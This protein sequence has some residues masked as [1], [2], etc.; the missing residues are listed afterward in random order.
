MNVLAL[1]ALV[2][3]SAAPAA[4]SEDYP[5]EPVRAVARVEPG[6]MVV[7]LTA[8][9]IY[10][11]EEILLVNPPPP[12]DWDADLSARAQAYVN[13]HLR[14]TTRGNPLPGR[15]V[16]ARWVQRL[17]QAHEQGS[18][19]LRLV[20]PPPQA[21]A[22]LSGR[23][24]FYEEYRRDQMQENGGA[25]PER[26]AGRFLTRVEIPGRARRTFELT[27]G[28][29]SF[30]LP[31]AEA[32]RTPGAMRL[33][34][35][36][37]GAAAAAGAVSAWPVL[38]ALALCLAGAAPAPRR[39]LAW[40]LAA[41][42]G[43]ALPLP[44]PA[45][46]PWAAGATAAAAAGSW[47]GSLPTLAVE[48]PVLVA[49]GRVWAREAAP[50]LPTDSPGTVERALA[51]AGSTLVAALIL[52]A[53]WALL[54]AERRRLADESQSHADTLFKRHKGLLATVALIV[55]G[56]GLWQVLRR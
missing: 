16:F 44:A 30:S 55:C 19:R 37:R 12:R 43:A 7:D 50:W 42:A 39:A 35:L 32:L 5:I 54:E 21:D 15:L 51:A 27:P 33:E 10:W 26:L 4:A 38:F 9:S 18:V 46:L 41:A 11:I 8:D 53:L 52:A 28:A 47:L 23:A 13:A 24:D 29:E 6:R 2:L 34:S 25:L 49:L 22:D 40:A 17:G 31:A 1:G 14:L 36:R 45:W 20:Y 48:L 56:G 3:L